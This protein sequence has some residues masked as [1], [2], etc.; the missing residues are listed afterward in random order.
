MTNLDP[1]VPPPAQRLP[2]LTQP[3]IKRDGTPLD[4]LFWTDGQW[5]RWQRGRAKKMGGYRYM[6]RYTAGPIRCAYVDARAQAYT[7]HTMSPWGIEALQFDPIT[8][9]GGGVTSRSPSTFVPNQN[10]QWQAAVLVNNGG[11]PAYICCAGTPDA[12]DISVDITGLCY[13]GDITTLGTQLVVLTSAGVPIPVSGGVVALGPFLFLYGSNGLI[14][15]SNPN[16]ISDATGWV[17]GTGNNVF[18]NTANPTDK[19]IVKGLPL[20]GG[21]YSPA[22]LFWALD[23]LIRVSFIGATGFNIWKYEQLGK[24]SI[25]A[26]NSVIEYDG[27]YYW[28]GVDRFFVYNGVVQELPNQMNL[29]WVYD[30]LD[31][32][33]VNYCWALKIPRYGEVW[34]FYPRAGFV[35]PTNPECTHAVIF[36]VRENTWYDCQLQRGAGME[37]DVFPN[38]IMTGGPEDVPNGYYLPFTPGVGTF[39]IG[40][41]VSGGTSGAV[42][43]V[44]RVIN[45]G[46]NS[47]TVLS[48]THA[49]TLGETITGFTTGATGTT[50]AASQPQDIDTVWI[51]EYGLDKVLDTTGQTAIPAFVTSQPISFPTGGPL[52]GAGQAQWQGSPGT[53]YMTRLTRLEPDFAAFGGG[54]RATGAMTLA[55]GGYPYAN[56]VS[57]AGAVQAAAVYAFNNTTQFIEMREQRREILLTIGSNVSGGFFELG[58]LILTIEQGDGR[59]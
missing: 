47:L 49:F 11:S 26:K 25:L 41:S 14:Q 39:A 43:V 10:L 32:A 3:G 13:Y 6:T 21:S 37:A 46:V 4:S 20:R 58:R 8:G 53:E 57:V 51:H 54:N 1:Q 27:I 50:L 38:P 15:N 31:Y 35:D 44:Y 30:N 24:I 9:A 34:W 29:N 59:P 18:A 56:S 16:N 45:V 28:M 40:E 22:G 5:V 36:N 33:H 42:G 17:I 52:A 19:K 48:P 12:L 55:V 23:M 2:L 7:L